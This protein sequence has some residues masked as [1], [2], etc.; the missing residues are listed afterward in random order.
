MS[1]IWTKQ[2]IR[3][4]LENNNEWLIRGIKAIYA[5]QTSNE[6]AVGVTQDHNDIGFNSADSFILSSF[7]EQII[8]HGQDP[9]PRFASPLSHKQLQLARRRMLKYAG[10]LEKIANGELQPA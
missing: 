3:A 1:K 7:A 9:N 4:A 8:K 10:Q 5:R 2:E 6:K